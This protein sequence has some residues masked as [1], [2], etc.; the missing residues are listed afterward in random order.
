MKNTHRLS[1]FLLTLFVTLMP[2]MTLASEHGGGGGEG[3][4]AYPGYMKLDPPVIVNLAQPGRGRLLK[5]SLQF[6]IESQ[7]DAD[8]VT[9]H[10]PRLRDRLI[11]LLGGRSGEQLMTAEAR[12]KLRE[13]LLDALRKTMKAETGKSAISELYF[14]D[15]IVQ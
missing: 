11:N 1:A 15:F 9:L 7:T 3:G 6:Y 5:L 10:M 14:T 13:E 12:E 8:L 4:A 2:V